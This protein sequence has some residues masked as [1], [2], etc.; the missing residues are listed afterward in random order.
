MSDQPAE[1]TEVRSQAA[2]WFAKLHTREIT[3]EALDAFREWRKHP[4]HRE[5]Y[6]EVEALWRRTGDLKGDAEVD[7]ALLDA[8]ARPRV[9]AR[10]RGSFLWPGLA[11]GLGVVGL[12]AGVL[13]LSSLGV[14]STAVGEQKLVR[15]EDGSRVRLDT[16][17]RLRVRFSDGA[18]RVELASGQAYF[19]VTGDPAR[20]FTVEA[21]GTVVRALGTKFDV[22]RDGDAVRATL[23]EGVIEVTGAPGR[24]GAWRLAPGQ[25][26]AT[27]QPRPAPVEV[28]VAQVT[29][30]TSGRI[31]FDRIPLAAAVAEVNRYSHDQIV[32]A[33]D[34][35]AGVPVSGAFD[36]GDS[37]AF[38]AA[39]TALHH[40]KANPL[41]GGDIQLARPG[42]AGP[43]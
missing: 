21:A 30:W 35:V 9:Q 8:F 17:T 15:L 23:I 40:L 10:R 42:A 2:A 28:D 32:L 29:S 34:D 11:V 37:Q 7:A 24:G 3:A 18:R 12:A 41:P 19:E 13:F 33:E 22:R 27:A 1:D 36:S 16:D 5:A 31:I 26:L 25:Q 43:S 14:V 4:G 6:A 20:P 39:V 38:V